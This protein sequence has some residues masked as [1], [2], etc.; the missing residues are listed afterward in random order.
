MGWVF[1][2]PSLFTLS[3]S[4]STKDLAKLDLEQ[5]EIKTIQVLPRKFDGKIIFEFHAIQGG[6]PSSTCVDGMDLRFDGYP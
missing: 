2:L 3:K 1:L 4:N 6:G 5:F